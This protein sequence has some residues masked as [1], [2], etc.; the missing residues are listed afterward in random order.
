M[1]KGFDI[2]SAMV[3]TRRQEKCTQQELQM[4]QDTSSS[5]AGRSL[6]DVTIITDAYGVY[7]QRAGAQRLPWPPTLYLVTASLKPPG[8]SERPC[9]S[10]PSLREM[11][12][13]QSQSAVPFQ[14]WG[15]AFML[16]SVHSKAGKADARS[17]SLDSLQPTAFDID[18]T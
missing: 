5:S 3:A 10:Y 9:T 7:G 1:E 13:T 11:T 4:H 14:I 16:T 18:N 2:D 8:C 17:T 15:P 6:E 12:T